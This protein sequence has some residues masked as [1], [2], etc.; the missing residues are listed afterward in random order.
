M[1]ASRASARARALRERR[2]PAEPEL[3]DRPGLTPEQTERA[4][5]GLARVNRLLLGYRPLVAAAR[6]RLAAGPAAQR[7][8]DLGT[9]AGDGAARVA[10]AAARSGVRLT[11]I[12]IDRKLGH[13]V[14]GRRLGHRQL[15]VVADAAALPLRAGA[16]NWSLSS[17][18]FH[19]FDAAANLV[20]LDE[21]RRVARRGAIVVDL[22]P[23]RLPYG[24]A[25]LLIPL[26]GGCPVTR[27]D[28]PASVARAWPLDAVRR[29]TAEL[30]VA[31][32]RRRFPFRWSLVIEAGG[33]SPHPP[34]AAGTGGRLP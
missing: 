10:R 33:R 22:R 11:V 28:G 27:H 1:T 34:G 30:P 23:G 4:L 7:L 6:P 29:L 31:E 17:L 24:L 15:R 18:F 9:G 16:C 5:R 13:L 12:G 2:E 14:V 8:V 19:H 3:L 21:M 32:L 20:V 26:V 25:R